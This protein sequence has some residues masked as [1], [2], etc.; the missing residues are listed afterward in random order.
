M[1]WVSYCLF[2]YTN[3]NLALALFSNDWAI[4]L[5]YKVWSNV[6][7]KYFKDVVDLIAKLLQ[8][9]SRLGLHLI[10]WGEPNRMDSVLPRWSESLLSINHWLKQ[11]KSSV[12]SVSIACLFLSDT[13]LP[14]SSSVKKQLVFENSWNVIDV[15]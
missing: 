5:K 8:V 10:Y 13:K 6:S 2:L 14:E 9:I 3:F 15:N 12:K 7:P 4:S 11:F 1:C